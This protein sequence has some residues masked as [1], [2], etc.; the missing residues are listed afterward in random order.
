MRHTIRFLLLALLITC[1]LSLVTLTHAA[2]KCFVCENGKFRVTLNSNCQVVSPSC[3]KDAT[4]EGVCV[5]P[6]ETAGNICES[7]FVLPSPST[8]PTDTI[9]EAALKAQN[10]TLL[11]DG[12]AADIKPAESRLFQQGLLATLRNLLSFI[13]SIFGFTP[14]NKE[15]FSAR[16]QVQRDVELPQERCAAGFGYLTISA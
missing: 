3:K 6:E 11:A 9:D 12:V 16:A 1:H 13:T 8:S 15:E 5:G 7:T 4:I 10:Q 2:D 14:K